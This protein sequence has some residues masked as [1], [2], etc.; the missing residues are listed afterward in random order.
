MSIMLMEATAS[1]LPTFAT[2]FGGP[3]EIIENEKNG[4]WINPT[5]PGL[6]T[7]PI[8]QF[9]N[10]QEKRPDHW[11]KISKQSILRIRKFYTW[12]LYSEKMIKFAKLYGFWNYSGQADE[13]KEIDHYCNLIFHLIFKKRLK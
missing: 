6:L 1:G 11:D 7:A 12:K 10:T 3:L 8:L 13:K 2:Q 9:F 5:Q 4:F